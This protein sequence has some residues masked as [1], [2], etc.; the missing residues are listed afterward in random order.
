MIDTIID[1]SH[2]NG[3]GL[4]FAAASAA[5]IVAVVHK[6]TQG[7]GY[8]DPMYAANKAAIQAAGLLF[9]SYHFG[10]GSDG[11]AQAQHFL[12]V[13]APGA[14]ELLALDLE[15]N[16]AGPSMTLE[17][18][19]AFVTVV[20][21]AIGKWPV[22][23]GGS[24]L[25]ALLGGTADPVLANCPLWLAQYGPAAVLPAGWTAWS[26]WQFT[27]GAVGNPPPVAGIG[28]CDQD[29]FAGDAA[30][31]AAFWASVSR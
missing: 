23:Y 21:G 30:G 19:K 22:L 14:N 6:C 20:Q 9:G 7:A 3:T 16:T 25:K 1:I 18:A 10:D 13:A 12:A 26:L 4:D 31:L 29:R 28:H 8:A 15:P 27:D 11:A 17:E 5:G 2:H 24:G